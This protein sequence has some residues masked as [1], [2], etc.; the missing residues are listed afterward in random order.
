MNSFPAST[1][2]PNCYNPDDLLHQASF[3]LFPCVLE[4]SLLAGATMYSMYGDVG[5]SHSSHVTD[6]E[7]AQNPDAMHDRSQERHHNFQPHQHYISEIDFHKA[8]RGIFFGIVFFSGSIAS[9]IIYFSSGSSDESLRNLI[10][11]ITLLSMN[12]IVL[13]ALVAAFVQ[14]RR[15]VIS[16]HHKINIDDVLLIIA[17]GGYFLFDLFS[18]LSNIHTLSEANQEHP[19]TDIL[20]L[21]N[22][23]LSL[24]LVTAQ[25]C[26]LAG[27]V[28][29]QSTTE[30][31]IRDK[32]GRGSVT[33]LVVA[34]LAMWM[35][36]T[37][38]LKQVAED[39]M[40]RVYYGELAWSLI[41]HLCL[42]LLMFYHFHS[43]A[44][45]AHV[46]SGAYRMEKH[47][48]EAHGLDNQ[49]KDCGNGE[50]FKSKIILQRQD[51]TLSED[52]R[53]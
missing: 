21:V 28:K 53:F 4:Y 19:E 36:T 37:F 14:I 39:S 42:P 9:L 46:W 22:N 16:V 44:C 13:F 26:F 12:T 32:P 41:T 52:Y 30:Q 48:N 45:L 17:M 1:E 34:N 18:V 23:I 3:Y 6:D 7:S 29:C 2:T 24:I 8:H 25:T 35:F 33:F 31:H 38:Q 27:A 49:T 43:S 11:F 5:S 47:E 20:S 50:A 15:L 40:A 10:F 51:S